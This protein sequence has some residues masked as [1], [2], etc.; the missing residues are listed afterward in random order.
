MVWG[1]ERPTVYR[2]LE[3]PEIGRPFVIALRNLLDNPTYYPN[4]RI[5]FQRNPRP[6]LVLWL[7]PYLLEES[8]QLDGDKTLTSEDQQ[9]LAEIFLQTLKF[10]PD[11]S[12]ATSQWADRILRGYPNGFLDAARKFLTLNSHIFEEIGDPDL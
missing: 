3:G 8:P 5:A 12:P 9:I 1:T 7:A 6:G 2:L 11:F 4:W 10:Y